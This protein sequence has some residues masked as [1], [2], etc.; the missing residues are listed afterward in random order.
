M[1][2]SITK[3][4][5]IGLLLTAASALSANA[6]STPSTPLVPHTDLRYHTEGAGINPFVGLEGFIPL[7]QAPA[8]LTFLQPEISL[9][10]GT[11]TF[12]GSLLV[13]HRFFNAARDRVY[14]GYFGYDLRDTG[15]STFHQ[16]GFGLEGLSDRVEFRINGYLPVGDT[17]RQLGDALTGTV[18]FQQNNLWLDRVR[19]FE[20]AMSGF[21]AEVGTRLMP[22][23]DGSLHGY[24]GMYYL[25][26][27]GDR[28]TVG[29]KGRLEARP[30][31]NVNVNLSVSHDGIFDTRVVLA[32]GINLTSQRRA[33]AARP[34]LDPRIERQAGIAV[35]RRSI[36]DA[37]LALNPATNQ[38]YLFRHVLLGA[39]IGTGTIEAPYGTVAAAV[40]VAQASDIIYVQAGNLSAI[41]AMTLPDGIT[42]LS[43]G[44]V[45]RLQTQ[46]GQV[47]LPLSGTG[48]LPRIVDATALS[49]VTLG[50]DNR[51]SGFSLENAVQ[52]GVFGSNIRNPILQD[53]RIL[54]AS[55]SAILLENVSG[56]AIATNNTIL[57]SGIAGVLVN[58]NQGQV[59][60]NQIGRAHV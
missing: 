57:N 25:N 23:G 9:S 44:P 7:L 36:H 52:N 6:Q 17:R 35:D 38:P 29:I 26:A 33:P 12:G 31:E 27:Q 13:G 59:A 53:N 1:S 42:L 54:N 32:V 48:V 47:V 43:T 51:V 15:H 16:L 3:P 37:I 19:R 22:L 60:I 11:S 5:V 58:N 20:T 28:S 21:D 46:L 30:N 56:T 10:T 8:S 49:L 50:N 2:Y 4:F 45:Q 41:P 55:R 34:T 14:G 40:Q 39:A 18:F 24:A